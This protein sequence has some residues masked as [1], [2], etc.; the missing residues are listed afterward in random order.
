MMKR[1]MLSVVTGTAAAVLDTADNSADDVCTD[2][3]N[4]DEDHDD[5][6]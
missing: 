6:D 2:E 5:E 1:I 3:Y 4:N